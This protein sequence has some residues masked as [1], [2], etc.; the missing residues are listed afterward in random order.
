MDDSENLTPDSG[1][2]PEDTYVVGYKKPP[3]DRRFQKGVSGNPKGRP[4]HPT[5]PREAVNKIMSEMHSI[6]INGKKKK[7]PALEVICRQ[8]CAKAMKGDSKA[9]ELLLK[10]FGDNIN[11]YGNLYVAPKVTPEESEEIEEVQGIIKEVLDERYWG[12]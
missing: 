8:L 6:T 4:K 9:T 11:I 5:N 3:K 12:K 2:K 1:K 10:H 7:I